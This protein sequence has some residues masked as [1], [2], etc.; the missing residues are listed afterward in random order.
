MNKYNGAEVNNYQQKEPFEAHKK[1][2][3]HILTAC[4]SYLWM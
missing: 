1:T 4:S 2:G 3:S